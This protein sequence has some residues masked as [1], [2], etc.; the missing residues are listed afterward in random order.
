MQKR[1][2]QII[3][4]F[5]QQVLYG[6]DLHKNSPPELPRD[7]KLR[8]LSDRGEIFG[9]TDRQ[10]S[11]HLLLVGSTGCGK[12]SVMCTILDQLLAG[13]GSKDLVLIFDA[14]GEYARR[15]FDPRN[16]RHILIGCGAE[17]MSVRHTWN[18]FGELM[19]KDRRPA[20]NWK[21]TANEIAKAIMYGHENQNQPFFSLAAETLIKDEIEDYMNTAIQNNDAHDLDTGHWRNTMRNNGLKEWIALTNK[22]GF[23]A[24]RMFFGG[25]EKMTAQA[26]GVFGEMNAAMEDTFSAFDGFRGRG[27]FSM[28]N[29]VQRKNGMV[30]FLEYDIA[31]GESQ[32]ALLRLWLDL[33]LKFGL[34]GNEQDRGRFYFVCDEL[35]LLPEMKH[36]SDAL[37]FGRAKGLRLICAQQSINQFHDAYGDRAESLL[38]GFCSCFA[39]RCYDEASRDYIS[40]RFGRQCSA[41]EFHTTKG[42][43]PQMWGSQVAEDWIIRALNTG[44]ALI[45]L[46]GNHSHPFRFHFQQHI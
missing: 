27:E 46:A 9:L 14:G 16:P 40:K 1:G 42:T 43:G 38:A 33:A 26:L 11:T 41:M 2:G 18:L 32:K 23:R 35:A 37:N 15:Y 34:G 17:Y 4:Q 25:D 5:S 36:L 10:L 22:E 7:A 30:V 6:E 31:M 45:D 13:L 12:T 44:E 39:F 3:M 21:V 19:G 29:L 24:H 20:P 28:R 8:F